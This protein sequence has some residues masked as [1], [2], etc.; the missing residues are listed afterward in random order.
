MNGKLGESIHWL[1]LRELLVQ[2]NS[3]EVFMVSMRV[4]L[5]HTYKGREEEREYL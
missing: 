1:N 3:Q 4:E 2:S 5:V